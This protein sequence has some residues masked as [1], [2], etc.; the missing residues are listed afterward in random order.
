MIQQDLTEGNITSKLWAF[1]LPF[2]VG[3]VLQQFY[4]LVDTWV[5]GKYIGSNALAAVGTAY[6]FMTFLI[7]IIIGFV[8]GAVLLSRWRWGRR[9]RT[10][11]EMEYLYLLYLLL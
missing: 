11:F 1:A 6:S 4:N 5:V 7:S 10:R 9:M 3:N 8:L 2:M